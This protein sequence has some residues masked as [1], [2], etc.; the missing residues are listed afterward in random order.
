M[1]V[2]TIQQQQ[3]SLQSDNFC[4]T[5]GNQKVRGPKVGKFV[6]TKEPKGFVA[7]LLPKDSFLQITTLMSNRGYETSVLEYP[8]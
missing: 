7:K 8:K 4:I 3:S 2:S 5:L 1:G 6:I